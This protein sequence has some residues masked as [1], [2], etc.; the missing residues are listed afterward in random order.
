MSTNGE[1]DPNA[2]AN[3]TYS[4]TNIELLESESEE[5]ILT[6]SEEDHLDSVIF[7][8]SDSDDT[9]E[10]DIGHN[11]SKHIFHEVYIPYNQVSLIPNPRNSSHANI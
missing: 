6:R 1:S 4:S 2:P 11:A 10:C 5:S 7:Y 3:A 8:G 9:C